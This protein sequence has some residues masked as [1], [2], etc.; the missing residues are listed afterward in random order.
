M[1]LTL[2]EMDV[3]ARSWQGW[4]VPVKTTSAHSSARIEETQVITS[5]PNLAKNEG[6]G[7][8]GFQGFRPKDASQHWGA[9]DLI[10]LP[11][12]LPRP[13]MRNAVIFI[14]RRRGLHNRSTHRRKGTQAGQNQLE[15]M[16][17]LASLG[18]KVL[19]TCSVELAMRYKGKLRVLSSFEEPSDTGTLV[20]DEEK[21]WN[22]C[23][24]WH[25][26]FPR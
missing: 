12:P 11:L 13:L 16:L 10:Q 17:E 19:Q 15:E 24:L 20:C 18:A 4:Q 14:Q 26:L 6:C 9:V 3:P 2:Q 1:A 5:W 7:C 23:G 25:R 21:S 22:Q 8:G